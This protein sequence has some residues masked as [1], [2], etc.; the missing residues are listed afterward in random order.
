M[1]TKAYTLASR[2]VDALR[3]IRGEFEAERAAIQANPNYSDSFKARLVAQAR[4][5]SAAQA[6]QVASAGQK[7][8]RQGQAEAIDELRR[9]TMSKDDEIDAN[10]LNWKTTEYLNALRS[11]PHDAAR[12]DVLNR[13]TRE[14][15]YSPTTRKAL[16]LAAGEL[17]H[18]DFGQRASQ[19]RN[20]LARWAEEERAPLEAAQA[21]L[22]AY[23]SVMEEYRNEALLQEEFFGG[24]R[25][26]SG[27][28]SDWQKSIF[29]ESHESLG[30]VVWRDDTSEYMKQAVPTP[31]APGGVGE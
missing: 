17:M 12:L 10:K 7:A 30:H 3:R 14:A 9:V 20:T 6:Y 8:L 15:Q 11:A 26:Y 23:P 5:W 1:T 31:A 19:A 4:E 24:Q 27:M 18:G 28:L 25:R 2:Y 29:D 16:S 13:L 21:Q 22:D